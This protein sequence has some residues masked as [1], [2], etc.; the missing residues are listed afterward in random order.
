MINWTAPEGDTIVNNTR[1]TI[2]PTISNGI[3]YTSS[4]QFTYLIEGDEG[5]YTCN[6]MIL[7]SSGSQSVELQLA[8]KPSMKTIYNY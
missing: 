3:T 4:L 8:S 7:E 2:N 5:N 1:M 6:W